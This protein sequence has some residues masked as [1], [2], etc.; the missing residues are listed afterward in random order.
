MSR[1]KHYGP[2][3]VRSMDGTE[4]NLDKRSVPLLLSLREET[5]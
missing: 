5:D 4:K 2:E 1:E 3:L